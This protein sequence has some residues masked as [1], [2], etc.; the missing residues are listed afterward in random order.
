MFELIHF[1]KNGFTRKAP[2]ERIAAKTGSNSTPASL[3]NLFPFF[4]RHIH[5]FAAGACVVLL[6]TTL[7]FPPPLITRYLID[8]VIS[9]KNLDQLAVTI[10]LLVAVK[11]LAL[12]LGPLEDFYFMRFGQDVLVDMQSDLIDHT[13]KLP[14]SF[15]DE[16]QTGYLVSRLVGDIQGLRWFFSGTPVYLISNAIRFIGGIGF[17]FYLE[18]RLALFVMVL[19]PLMV[20]VVIFFSTRM[21]ILSL[22]GMEN[23]G[24]LM[25]VS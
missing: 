9:Q 25:Q 15:F 14:K 3:R 7:A 5:K 11:G 20:L 12:V 1:I 17:L 21:R 13:L 19:L 8:N 18:W 16:Q 22:N 2:V 10:L 4:K 6:T 24:R 23:Q